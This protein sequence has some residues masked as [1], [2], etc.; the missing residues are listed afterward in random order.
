MNKKRVL[1][2]LLMYLG[3]IILGYLISW[4]SNKPVIENYTSVN[5]IL[6][7]ML[8]NPKKTSKMFKELLGTKNNLGFYDV[9]DENKLNLL[10]KELFN[11]S[12][13]SDKSTKDKKK[14]ID[15]KDIFKISLPN[16]KNEAYNNNKMISKLRDIK[17]DIKSNKKDKTKKK[18]I[19]N[20][21]RFYQDYC[22]FVPTK[23]KND[24]CPKEYPVFIGAQFS[25]KDI[26]C[27]TSNKKHKSKMNHCKL[28]C[29]NEV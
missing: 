26:T 10:K 4:K 20:R 7:G 19:K 16:F 15:K 6:K 2:L 24:A 1:M 18:P 22:K 17:D 9:R 27:G 23:H 29:K 5:T 11:K 13:E 25:G 28:C 21:Q 3:L 12:D 14:P 8:D